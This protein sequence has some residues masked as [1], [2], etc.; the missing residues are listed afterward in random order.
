MREGIGGG[1]G[2]RCRIGTRMWETEGVR[3]ESGSGE[4]ARRR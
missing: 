2:R 4:G 1:G 3:E